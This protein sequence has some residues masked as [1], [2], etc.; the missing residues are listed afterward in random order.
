[1]AIP[2]DH[3]ENF[4]KM[5]NAKEICEAIKSRFGGNDESNKMQKYLL[6]Q[7]CKSFSVSSSEGVHKGYDR[8]QSLLSQLE[9]H[10]VDVS[11][12]DA[13][14]KFLSGPQLDHEDL[15]QI[16][17]FELEDMDLKWQMAMISTRL[18]KF[19]KKTRKKVHFVAKEPV[20]FD[21]SKVECFNCHNTKHFAIECRSKGNQD[22]RRRD[23]GNT[24]YKARDNGKRSTKQGEH[25]AMVTIDGEGSDTEDHPH[26]TLKRK[27]II[28]SGC[29]RHMTRNKAYLVDYQ[30]FNGGPVAFGGS[31]CQITG[32]GKIKTRKLDFEDVYFVKELHHFNLFSVSQMCDKKN[33]VL[34]IETKC[35]ILCLDFKLPD[36]NQVLLKVLRQHNM[37]SFNLKNIVLSKALACLIVKATVDKSTKWHRR[38]I[39]EFCGSKGIKREYISTACYVLKRVLVTKRQNKTPYEL[40]TGKIPILSYTRPFGCHVTILNTIDHLGKFEEKSDKGFLVGYSLSS[41]A[42]RNKAN[43]TAG[44]KETNNSAGTQDSFDAGNYEIEADHAQE[45]YV[46][47]LWSSYTSTIKSSKAKNGDE[48]LNEDTNLKTNEEPIDHE[49]QAFLEELER[50]KRQEK[51]ANDATETLRKTLED[52]YEVLRDGIFTSES[53]DDEGAVADFTNLETTVNVS[54]IPTSKIHSIHPTTQILGDSTLA[55]Q[56]RSKV[57]KSF[58]PYVFGHR[59]E[60]RIDYDEVFAHV[61]KIEA[62]RIFLAFSTYMEFIV[63]QMDVKSAFLYG[64]INK[65]NRLQMSSIGELTFFL[66]LQVKQKEDGIFISQDKYVAEILK[67]FDFLNVKTASIPIET[68]KPLV[69]DEEAAD[70]DVT[71]NTSHLQ[72]MKRIFRYLKG[73]LKLGLWYPRELAFDMEAYSDSDY[74][75]ANLDRKSITGEYVVAARCCEQVLWIQNQI[76]NYGFNFMNTKIYIHNE[77]TICIVKNLVFHS[78][79]KHIEIRHHFIRDAYEKKLIQGDPQAALRDTGIFDSGCSRHMIGNKSFLSDYQEDD[80]GFVVFAGSSK[81]GKITGKGKI[82]T[83]KLD[84]EDMYFVKELKF[85][86]FSVSHMCDKKNSVLFIETECLNLSPNF[87]LPDENQVLLKVPRKNNMYSFDLKNVVPLKGLTCLI[88]KATNDE[89]NLWHRRLGHINSKTIDKLVKGNLVRGIPSKIFEND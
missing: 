80:G 46:L 88:E 29:S 68:K 82:R 32:K 38:D 48:K 2:E 11:T 62:I 50:L 9:T 35:L 87:K 49:D 16:D 19:Y 69:K 41:K 43:K 66:R 77:S 45:Y 6:K 31:I 73:Q 33:N 60:E 65:E 89:S 78:K 13:N 71:L 83:E 40:L 67:K 23:G 30:D 18:K 85:N 20:G 81:G 39:I 54:P 3:L 15:E 79:T 8:F 14:Q 26:Q 64:K 10:G 36:E 37:C 34:F 70:V 74:A 63:Y 1:M 12:E 17:E 72:A 59:Q 75:G 56:T 52:I 42:F 22:S 58:G 21:K 27:S 55:V 57:N 86:L 25:K 51:E 53:Y 28:D 47:P 76:L 7:Q 24:R 84:F 4:H 5:T 61:P 44:P